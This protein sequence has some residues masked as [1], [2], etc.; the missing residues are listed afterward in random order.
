MV[1][2]VVKSL[3]HFNPFLN[4][5]WFL[6]VC[7]SN[8]LKT[9]KLKEKL[10]IMSNSSFS[11]SVFYSIG[12]L[13]AILIKLKIVICK[14]FQFGKSLTYVVRERIKNLEIKCI[15]IILGKKMVASIF[16]IAWNIPFLPPPPQII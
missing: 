2:P 7:S 16:S 12:E 5:P 15:G 1:K 10:L 11:C 6:H 3:F 13:S 8:L 14:L 4:K 9:L